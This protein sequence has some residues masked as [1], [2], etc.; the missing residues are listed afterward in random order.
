ME[1]DDLETKGIYINHRDVD[2]TDENIYEEQKELD[3]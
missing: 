2:D 1:T 3:L